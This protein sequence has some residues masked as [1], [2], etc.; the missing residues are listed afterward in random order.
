MIRPEVFGSSAPPPFCG[1][2]GDFLY[3]G[4]YYTESAFL[5]QQLFEGFQ[6]TLLAGLG[7]LYKQLQKKSDHS[8]NESK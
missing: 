2:L 1:E 3:F 7:A 5:C 4:R 8:K 6:R